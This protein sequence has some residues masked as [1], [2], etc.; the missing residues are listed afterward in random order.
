[1]TL[2]RSL[3][4]RELIEFLMDYVEDALAPD[5]RASF[6]AHL[7]VCPDCVRY[8]DGYRAT[9]RAGRAAFAEPEAPVPDEVPEALVAAIL[10]ARRGG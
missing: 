9:V 5:E 2:A 10:R 1:M 4:C 8:L 7:A 6:D 3:T